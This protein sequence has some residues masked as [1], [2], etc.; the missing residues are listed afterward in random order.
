MFSGN[1]DNASRRGNSLL[2]YAGEQEKRARAAGTYV[3]LGT[4]DME[5]SAAELHR[6][7]RSRRERVE[8]AY[9]AE[10]ASRPEPQ[11]LPEP[12]PEPP[13]PEPPHASRSPAMP[14]RQAP[15]SV[16]DAFA[17]IDAAMSGRKAPPGGGHSLESTAPDER[18]QA[19]TPPERGSDVWRPLI[20]PRHIIAAVKSWGAPIVGLGILGAALGVMTALSTPKFYYASAE[21]SIDPRGLK[22]ID[23]GVNPDGFVS[24]TFA[25]VDSQVRLMTSPEVLEKVVKD[26]ALQDD[27]EFN[28]DLK[29]SWL[30]ILWGMI[31]RED[32]KSDKSIAAAEYLA[33]HVY[34]ERGAKTYNINVTSASASPEKAAEIANRVVAVY[35]EKHREQQSA[36]VQQTTDELT[37]RL[38]ALKLSV[39][40][41][42]QAVEAYKAEN[43]LIGVEGRLIDDEAILRVN[44]QLSAAKGQTINLNARAKSIKD[45]TPES[46]VGGGVSDDVNSP[47]LTGLRS[48]YS[49]AKQKRDGMATKLGPRHPERIAAESELESLRASIAAEIRR[50][51]ASMQADLRR[52]VQTEQD[53]AGYLAELKVKQGGSG[54]DLVKL[55]ELQRDAS[56]KGQVYEAFIL[57]A[58]Q[59]A[60]QVNLN[61]ADIKV[62]ISARPPKEPQGT[63]RKLIVLAGL[64]GGLGLGLALAVLKGIIASIRSQ[65]DNGDAAQDPAP[66][67]APGGGGMFQPRQ[68]RDPSQAAAKP[69]SAPVPPPHVKQLAE[70]FAPA[71]QDQ[72]EP[73]APKLQSFRLYPQPAPQP[74]PPQFAQPAPQPMHYWQPQPQMPPQGFVPPGPMMYPQQAYAPQPAFAPQQMF[75]P[76]PPAAPS[77]PQPAPYFAFQQP[78]HLQMPAAS[79]PPQPQFFAPPPPLAPQSAA[80]VP[81]A[82][83]SAAHPFAQEA[84]QP[85]PATSEPPVPLRA[86]AG[87]RLS[88]IQESIDEFRSALTSFAKH[89]RAS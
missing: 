14:P 49:A 76:Q 1:G 36:T 67:P 47:A 33:D 64:L 30:D 83:Q 59:T 41:S 2:R 18:N 54:A 25:I 57:R 42:E 70:A 15:Q 10:L 3:S 73:A 38:A 29:S 44:D 43:D 28:G 46:L 58:K 89:R 27:P 12:A 11:A 8:N 61:T 26:L 63:S 85:R 5:P 55:R 23:N 39:E 80:A 69:A 34:V 7:A 40:K 65:M 16:L 53:L 75:A 45:L 32:A 52:A 22:V 4:P 82:P 71:Q 35:V 17:R 78:V 74:A 66:R 84:E 87:D 72:R 19:E 24:D 13:Q 62:V 86:P 20:D 56:A 31:L 81:A 21:L 77:W 37:E 51:S 50:I 48:Q 6:R 68:D 60:E 79:M 88:Q 9:L